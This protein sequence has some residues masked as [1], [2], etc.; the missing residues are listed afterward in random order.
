MAELSE[1]FSPLLRVF[2]YGTLKPGEANYQQYCADKVV[3]TI[4][5]MAFGELFALPMGYPAMTLG[6]RPVHGY[7]LS[8]T[9]L[10]ILTHLD[11]LE[12]YQSTRDASENLYDRQQIEIYD[13][14]GRSLG[15]A[16]VYL[17]TKESVCQLG[18]I[19]QT[20]G[21]WTGNGK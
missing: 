6:D 10:E 12:D 17:M 1:K 15:Y 4:K 21:C 16:W 2:V 8:F 13:Q 3:D 19:L 20:D 5:A 11:E 7:L 9:D 14:Q 18:G